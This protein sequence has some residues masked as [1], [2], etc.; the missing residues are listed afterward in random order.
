M[1]FNANN[2]CFLWLVLD[3]EE[4]SDERWYILCSER[5]WH[6][7][8]SIGNRVFGEALL[9]VDEEADREELDTA[10]VEETATK[11]I[12]DLY[13]KFDPN[14]LPRLLRS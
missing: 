9:R 4:L 14:N 13:R 5:H 3:T 7:R 2:E 12:D 8:L 10:L 1:P 11:M 6:P